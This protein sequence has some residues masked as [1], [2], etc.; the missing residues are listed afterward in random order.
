MNANKLVTLTCILTTFSVIAASDGSFGDTSTGSLNLNLTKGN[1]V[2]LSGLSDISFGTVTSAPSDKFIDVCVYSST[3]SYD[4]TA[5]S[6]NPSG[7]DFRLAN[8]GKTSFIVYN[9]TWNDSASG[10]GGTDL[11]NSH[12]STKFN[13]ADTTTPDCGGSKNARMFVQ[14]HT[15]T[16]NTAT[17]G[18]YSD[19]LTLVVS[20]R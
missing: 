16:F 5:T 12:A 13:N 1:Q 7:T 11:N 6:S 2:Q 4:V 20:P 18:I 3:G 15:P 8:L 10:N 9:V 19:V 17:S 14:I